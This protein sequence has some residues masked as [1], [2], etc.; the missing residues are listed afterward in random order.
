MKF[1][2][3]VRGIFASDDNPHKNGY[4]VRSGFRKGRLNPGMYYEITDGN[5]DFWTTPPENVEV[6]NESEELP[7]ANC[8]SCSIGP[9][10]HE[11]DCPEA[12]I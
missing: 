9:D 2:Q 7:D 12:Q 1:G 6:I 8:D 10:G 11:F 5:G 3:R 4:F